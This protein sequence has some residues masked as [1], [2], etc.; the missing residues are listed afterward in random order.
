MDVK[1][2]LAVQMRSD[3]RDWIALCPSI[4]VASQAH[5][6]REA[7]RSLREGVELWF[8][9]CI[10]RNVLSEA[11]SASGFTRLKAGE[12]LPGRAPNTVVTR[13]LLG[14]APE[15]RRAE[16]SAINFA[17]KRISGQNFVEGYIPGT[18]ARGGPYYH[19]AV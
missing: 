9:S 11:L 5:T 13:N 17:V 4:D 15:N 1:I 10:G 2:Q 8:E 19:V 3:G 14:S 16:S 7:L 18:L 12:K 6:K